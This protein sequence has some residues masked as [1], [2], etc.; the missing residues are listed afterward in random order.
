[1]MEGAIECVRHELVAAIIVAVGNHAHV[2]VD[3][4]PHDMQMR[5][6]RFFRGWS[7]MGAR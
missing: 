7:V 2:G 6:A 5:P 4:R 3:P 1:M